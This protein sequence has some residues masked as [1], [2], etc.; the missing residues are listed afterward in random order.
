MDVRLLRLLVAAPL[1]VLFGAA[2]ALA[3]SP[4]GDITARDREV[5]ARLT[6]GG[7]Q[8][9][10]AEGSH[11]APDGIDAADLSPRAPE[12]APHQSMVADYAWSLP[13]PVFDTLP[14]SPAVARRVDRR[15]VLPSR[16]RAP[17]RQ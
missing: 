9:L 16:G 2:M 4:Q 6:R 11:G 5:V 3:A 8:R 7:V 1:V 13:S 15:A 12:T 14:D 10:D 17:P